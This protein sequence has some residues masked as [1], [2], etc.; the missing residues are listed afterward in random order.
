MYKISYTCSFGSQGLDSQATLRAYKNICAL[1]ALELVAFFFFTSRQRKYLLSTQVPVRGRD[2][3][4]S[5]D[6]SQIQ[7]KKSTS[8]SSVVSVPAILVPACGKLCLTLRGG[9]I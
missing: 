1:V 9:L 7:N 3:F 8:P 2:V 4:H 6:C 5:H